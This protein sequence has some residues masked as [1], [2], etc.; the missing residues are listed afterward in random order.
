MRITRRGLYTSTHLSHVYA[1][2]SLSFSPRTRLAAS[3][4]SPRRRSSIRERRRGGELC[5]ATWF[6]WPNNAYDKHPLLSFSC[7]PPSLAIPYIALAESSV[8]RCVV[9]T[10]PPPPSL[11][12]VAAA[13]KHFAREEREKER[14][15]SRHGVNRV[16]PFPLGKS[17]TILRGVALV[18]A[19]PRFPRIRESFV[20]PSTTSFNMPRNQNASSTDLGSER[21]LLR[22]QTLTT[23]NLTL[24]MK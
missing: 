11:R 3:S 8:S 15:D 22:L 12:P 16:Y 23:G 9:T 6:Y 19:V 24:H 18:A 1:F 20:I 13:H 7:P 17:M 21:F 4:H 5:A 10:R 2:R 14:D